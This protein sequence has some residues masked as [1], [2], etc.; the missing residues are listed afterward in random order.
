MGCTKGFRSID[1]KREF[2]KIRGTFLGVI[3]SLLRMLVY[4][5]TI[6]SKGF[7]EITIFIM[8]L[9]ETTAKP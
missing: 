1:H 4:C 9:T 5:F 8:G 6:K 7:F 2:P 3:C